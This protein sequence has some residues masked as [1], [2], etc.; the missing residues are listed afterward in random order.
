MKKLFYK[1]YI[2]LTAFMLFAIVIAC[3]SM[4][5]NGELVASLKWLLGQVYLAFGL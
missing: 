2:G 5:V 4:Y 3:Y 1:A